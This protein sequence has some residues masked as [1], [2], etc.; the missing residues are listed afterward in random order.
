MKNVKHAKRVSQKAWDKAN[1]VEEKDADGVPTGGAADIS[2]KI[3][4]SIKGIKNIPQD[5]LQKTKNKV[6]I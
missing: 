4:D 3:V 5:L 6:D 1:G 2:E